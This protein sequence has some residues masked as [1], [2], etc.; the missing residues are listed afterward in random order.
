VVLKFL[1]EERK[2]NIELLEVFNSTKLHG[3][4]NECIRK[5]NSSIL[6]DIQTVIDPV[7]SLF[8]FLSFFMAFKFNFD[9]RDEL[10]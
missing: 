3:Y 4:E 5:Y 1:K 10:F 2:A 6:Y 7:V 9:F 8:L